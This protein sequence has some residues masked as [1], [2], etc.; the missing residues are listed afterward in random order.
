[1]RCGIWPGRRAQPTTEYVTV[2][3]Q[4]GNDSY[5]IDFPPP[6]VG[7]LDLLAFGVGTGISATANGSAVLAHNVMMVVGI[8]PVDAQLVAIFGVSGPES[9]SEVE[10]QMPS[11]PTTR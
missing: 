5:Q 7:E 4:V 1:L 9:L 10:S 2:G 8:V 3:G 11:C 6:H